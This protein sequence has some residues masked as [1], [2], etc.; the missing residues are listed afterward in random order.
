MGVLCS[1]PLLT[2]QEENSPGYKSRDSQQLY[3]IKERKDFAFGCRF[4]T[5]LKE[6]FTRSQCVIKTDKREFIV[7][8][9]LS[10]QNSPQGLGRVPQI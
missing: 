4:T 1:D 6:V 2:S 3:E 7:K 5:L 9:P 8:N 10:P